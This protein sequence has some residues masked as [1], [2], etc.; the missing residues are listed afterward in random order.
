MGFLPR[1]P[2]LC[3]G[4]SPRWCCKTSRVLLISSSCSSSSSSM[5]DSM[6]SDVCLEMDGLAAF[7]TCPLSSSS[8]SR[9]DVSDDANSFNFSVFSSSPFRSKL[10]H[11]PIG[12]SSLPETKSNSMSESALSLC[13]TSMYLFSCESQSHQRPFHQLQVSFSLSPASSG[14]NFS[15]AWNAWAGSCWGD[16][17]FRTSLVCLALKAG[18]ERISSV[19]LWAPF[20]MDCPNAPSPAFRA[21]LLGQCHQCL[22]QKSL[23]PRPQASVEAVAKLAKCPLE[24]AAL[25]EKL[26]PLVKPASPGS[27]SSESSSNY[28]NYFLLAVTWKKSM[29]ELAHSHEGSSMAEAPT[30]KL[31]HH[32]D[33]LPA[34]SKIAFVARKLGV[35]NAKF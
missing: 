9:Q 4:A 26:K 14:S 22:S 15:C 23:P 35:A 20:Q 3:T 6:S 19:A 29:A 21:L 12:S 34:T 7:R 27:E 33:C 10:A 11:W 25:A 17:T 1:L 18:A 30:A 28:F 5:I 31:A 16:G 24:M 13:S 2:D 8:T 32:W